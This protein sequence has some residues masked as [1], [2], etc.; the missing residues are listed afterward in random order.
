[1]HALSRRHLLG[2]GVTSAALTAAPGVVSPAAAG[3]RERIGSW[4]APFDLRGVAI[5]LALLHTDQL[6]YFSSVEGD[7][8]VDRTS[9]VRTYDLAASTIREPVTAPAGIGYHRDLFCAGMNVLP[10]GR[11]FVPGGHDHTTGEHDTEG[12][13]GTDVFDPVT[14]RWTPGPELAVERWYPTSVSMPSGRTLVMGGGEDH[15]TPAPTMESYDPVAGTMRTLPDT[16]TRDLGMYPR[17]HLLRNGNL[18]KTGPGRRALFFRPAAKSWH[19]GPAMGYGDRLAG[20]SVLLPGSRRLLAF[21]G[22]RTPSGAPTAS[23]EV[24]DLTART[25]AWRAVG[26]MVSARVHANA[27]LLPDGTVLAIGGGRTRAYADPVRTAEIFDPATERWRQ[28]AAQSAQRMYHATAALLPDGRVIS[29]GSDRGSLSRTAEIYRPPYLYRGARPVITSAPTRARYGGSL[30]VR[31]DLAVSSLVLMR[32]AVMTHQ[33]DTEQRA[34]P[35]RF[36]SP[37]PG[38]YVAAAPRDAGEAPPGYYMLF[39]VTSG[40]VPSRATWVR[41]QP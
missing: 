34:V 36:T 20:C 19:R 40:G 24:L 14:R 21:G 11:V 41:V 39:A 31:T 18:V 8:D 1:M 25:P 32:P 28:V 35:L 10:D 4:S 37:A 22:R 7:P 29:A 33:V 3:E 23:T 16:A 2:A 15:A 38:E 12:W 6:L 27:V 5:H 26:R 9:L 30:T 13:R 17:V